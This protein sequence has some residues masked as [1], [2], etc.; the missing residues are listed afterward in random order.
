MEFLHRYR[1]GC[2]FRYILLILI[3]VHI[4]N[5]YRGWSVEK[6]DCGDRC[7]GYKRQ[8]LYIYQK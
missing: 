1:N 3:I 4:K 8:R 5:I 7:F 2:K 6:E